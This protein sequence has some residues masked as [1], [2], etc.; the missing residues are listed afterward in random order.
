MTRLQMET[1]L[2]VLGYDRRYP[3]FPQWRF[4]ESLFDK[5]RQS[6]GRDGADARILTKA[7]GPERDQLVRDLVSYLR[8]DPAFS[9][10]ALRIMKAVEASASLQATLGDADRETQAHIARALWEFDNDPRWI[11]IIANP[12]VDNSLSEYSRTR[13]MGLLHHVKHTVAF[14]ALESAMLDDEYLVRRSAAVYYSQNSARRTAD[15]TIDNNVR[16]YDEDRIR[17]FLSKLRAKI[18]G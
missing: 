4:M 2:A 17:Q 15:S 13:L 14:A 18:N 6:A 9:A 8:V 12:I 5:Y 7:K 10:D 1:T 16:E 3:P 11:E